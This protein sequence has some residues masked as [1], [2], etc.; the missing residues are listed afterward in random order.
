MGI[1]I[2]P[3]RAGTLART[4]CVA[5][6]LLA[7]VSIEERSS[8]NLCLARGRRRRWLLPCMYIRYRVF[9]PRERWHPCL[10]LMYADSIYTLFKRLALRVGYEYTVKHE[11]QSTFLYL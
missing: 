5:C 11:V 6:V 10:Y 9:V 1:F 4:A 8:P 3:L 7:Y 2:P